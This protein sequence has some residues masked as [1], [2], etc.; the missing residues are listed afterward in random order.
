[1]KL[2]TFFLILFLAKLSSCSETLI[3]SVKNNTN[4]E[5]IVSI[6]SSELKLRQDTFWYPI[7]SSYILGKLVDTRPYRY[8]NFMGCENE[9][10]DFKG[11]TNNYW[12]RE[13]SLCFYDSQQNNQGNTIKLSFK[14]APNDNLELVQYPMRYARLDKGVLHY[15][16]TLIIQSFYQPVDLKIELNGFEA[17]KELVEDP[18]NCKTCVLPITKWDKALSTPF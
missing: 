11:K 18:E 12:A 9:I 16:D 4:E 5:L 1:M 13:D 14:L 6:I 7:D 2:S 15:M 17:I 8:S 3:F 10:V